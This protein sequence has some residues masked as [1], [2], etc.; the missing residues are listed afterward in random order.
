MKDNNLLEIKHLAVSFALETGRIRAIDDVG[1]SVPKGKTLG[2]VGESGCGKSVTALSVMRLLPKPS[3]EIEQGEILFHKDDIVA[4]PQDQMQK[5]RGNRISMIFQEPMTALNPVHRIGRQVEEV[6]RLHFPDM[7][8]K[9]R[10]ERSIEMLMNVGIPDPVKRFREYPHQLSGGMRQRVMISIALACEPELLIA[11]EPTTALDVT[12]QAQILE[13]IATLQKDTGMSV[14][15]ITHDLGVIAETCD[16]VVVLY[17]GRVAERGDTKSLF[18]NPLHPYTRGLLSSIP[19]L[20]NKAKSRLRVIKG[21]V[22][23]LEEFSKGCRFQ[24]RCSEAMEI[25]KIEQP[26]MT[27][28]ENSHAAACH[29]LE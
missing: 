5:I 8:K 13:L 16:D 28:V 12:I 9:Q 6:F 23:G 2:L 21:M 17:A 24:N 7:K 29:L 22:P 20:E 4:L 19:R 26:G 18:K 27:V 15:F 1:F 25:C 11:D 14:M 10:R 3:A